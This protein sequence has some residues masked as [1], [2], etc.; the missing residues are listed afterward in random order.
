MQRAEV[1]FDIATRK[2]ARAPEQ[3]QTDLESLLFE[4]HG[5]NLNEQLM[6]SSP[7]LADIAAWVME[8]LQMQHPGIITVEVEE[9]PDVRVTVRREVRR[10]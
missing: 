4:V 1:R 2:L 5:R 10:Q 8:R 7:T 6:G 9:V 3:L